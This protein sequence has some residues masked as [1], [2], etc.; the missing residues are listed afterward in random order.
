[1]RRGSDR[2]FALL[3]LCSVLG[4]DPTKVE[5]QEAI[6]AQAQ[7]TADSLAAVAQARMDSIMAAA[8]VASTT[9]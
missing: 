8:A 1:M 9:V 3:L 4:C 7:A 2:V 5:E 6:A